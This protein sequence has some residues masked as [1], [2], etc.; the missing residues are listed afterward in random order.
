ML[1][2]YRKLLLFRSRQTVLI[3]SEKT[4]SSRPYVVRG[5][6]YYIGTYGYLSIFIFMNDTDP[7]Q[8]KEVRSHLNITL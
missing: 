4:L 5:R 6:L 3:R 8:S 2:N 1:S 7:I